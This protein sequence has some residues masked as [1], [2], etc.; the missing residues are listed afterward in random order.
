MTE[1]V[2]YTPSVLIFENGEV[3]GFL[4]P[5]SDADLTYY[6]TSAAFSEWISQYLDTDTVNGNIEN[7]AEPCESSCSVLGG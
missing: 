3:K 6:K 2:S 5:A 1:R 4:D 7:T